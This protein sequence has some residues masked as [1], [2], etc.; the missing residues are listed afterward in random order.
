MKKLNDYLS[1]FIPP[2]SASPTLTPKIF[3]VIAGIQVPWSGAGN[4]ACSNLVGTEKCP[5]KTGVTYTYTATIPVLA[6]YP[7]VSDYLTIHYPLHLFI[8]PL[9]HCI[10]SL[11][12]HSKQE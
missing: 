3:G 4:N 8:V 2:A 11:H 6:S 9:L 1:L 12:T 7:A 5:L 10:V